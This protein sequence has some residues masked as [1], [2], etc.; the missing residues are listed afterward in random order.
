MNKQM[1]WSTGA[2]LA[3][4][5]AAPALAQSASNSR[6][7][8]SSNEPTADEII[9]T[10]QRREERL[11]ET[12]ISISVV[13]GQMLDRSA[14]R[15]VADAL[16]RVPGVSISGVGNS[17]GALI[18]MRGVSAP[19]ATFSGS[20]PV[21]YYLDTLPFALVK[22]AIVP[23]ASGYDLERVEVLR[24]PQGTLYGVNS[25][26]GVVRILTKD[27]DLDRFEIKGRAE[28]ATTKWGDPSY[29]ADTAINVPLSEG[30][31]AIR[32]VGGYQKLGGWIDGP[33][34]NDLNDGEVVNFRL[35]VNAQPTERLSVGLSGWHSRSDYG[36][37]ARSD[38]AHRNPSLFPEKIS[39]GFDT[40]GLKLKYDFDTFLVESATSYLDYQSDTS[41]DLVSINIP[42]LVLYTTLDA[43]VLTEEINVR[44]TSSG[45]WR[46]SA[47]A[48]YRD[49]KDNLIQDRQTYAGGRNHPIAYVTTANTAYKSRS[50][51]LYGEVGRKFAN[52]M[53]EVSGGLRYFRDRLTL[54]EV[55]SQFGF[56]PSIFRK[57][58]FKA[59]TPSAKLTF[60]PNRDLMLYASYSEGFRSG[61]HQQPA[62]L[63]TVPNLP[64]AK[65][66][67]LRNYEVGAKGTVL[68]GLLT[69]DAALYKIEWK[70]VQQQIVITV[71]ANAG[72]AALINGQSASGMGVDLGVTM[73][74][75]PGLSF[76]GSLSFN[77]L[78]Q[79]ANVISNNVV[80]F[81]KGERL[82][83][84]PKYTASGSV[85]YAVPLGSLEGRFSGTLSYLSRIRNKSL[86]G[87][88][89]TTTM[90]ES[91]LTARASF[92][93]ESEA[94]WTATLFL[95]N[96]AND[97]GIARPGLAVGYESRNRPRTF[98]LQLEYKLR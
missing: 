80:L 54:R 61:A 44:S 82:N 88:T 3:L 23:D 1:A 92:A 36:T 47:G 59:T 40:L 16:S 78:G 7:A 64:T 42:G 4:V 5:L 39:N 83:E 74:P 51:A 75:A 50:I 90:S 62:A 43:K 10:A 22:T 17:G 57:N 66:D 65:P 73:R 96:L 46:W 9:V 19:G 29:R 93:L 34:G 67:L 89:V 70:D 32:A 79:D 45:P 24:G 21:G 13:S 41:I 86:S 18:G 48:L 94:G 91:I 69:F 97:Y 81:T 72:Q 11:Q 30:K 12:P 33:L 35:K 53:L 95:E 2:S 71:G 84:S 56:P 76:D 31:L 85:N 8:A 20:S 15:T 77:D 58:I 25:E 98:G 28:L 52:D 6:P 60:K 14:D 63:R 27:A 37:P 49:G 87:T 55:A 26:I 68:D 38:N